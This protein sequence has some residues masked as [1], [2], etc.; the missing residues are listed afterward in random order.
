MQPGSYKTGFYF[1]H[2]SLRTGSLFWDE[3]KKW[4]GEG[5]KRVRLFSQQKINR[6][7]L[8]TSTEN[9]EVGTTGKCS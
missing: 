3:V 4:R 8:F 7:L 5:R 6:I 1:I 2:S 9:R